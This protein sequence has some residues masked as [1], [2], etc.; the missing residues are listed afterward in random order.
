M[1]FNVTVRVIGMVL[2]SAAGLLLGLYLDQIAFRGAI[3][4][5]FD[6]LVLPLIIISALFGFVATPYVTVYP[7]RWLRGRLKTMPALDL[8]AA[9]CGLSVGL[10]L[11]ALFTWPL[12][13]L[14]GWLGDLA[15][16]LVTLL[17]A[18]LGIY[19]AVLRRRDLLE[20]LQIGAERGGEVHSKSASKPP[21]IETMGSAS[22]GRPQ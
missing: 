17:F 11:G 7:I 14:P 15:P 12:S 3:E 5:G 16:T 19:V 13:N 2:F 22:N 8:T 6:Q 10:V 9:A 21:R 1:S 20:L 18:W 4:K